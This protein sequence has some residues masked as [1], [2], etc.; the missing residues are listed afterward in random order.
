MLTSIEALLKSNPSQLLDELEDIYADKTKFAESFNWWLTLAEIATQK[1]LLT[2]KRDAILWAKIASS[3]F[4]FLSSKPEAVSP[5]SLE[6]SEMRVRLKL[7]ERFGIDYNIEILRTEP[8]EEWFLKRLNLDLEE[9]LRLSS[10][11]VNLSVEQIRNLRNLK[12]RI[13]VIKILSE[14][15]LMSNNNDLRRWIELKNKLP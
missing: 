12:S 6:C 5:N 11:W 2:E 10:S 15:G 8:I 3:V 4:R 9:T 14:M 7:I 1:M 13:G